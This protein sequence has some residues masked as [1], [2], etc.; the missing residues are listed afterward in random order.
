MARIN[1]RPPSTPQSKPL[2]HE[3]AP[4][5]R[6]GALAQ[7]RRSVLACLL[8][9]DTFYEN[10]QAIAERIAT[11]VPQCPPED[12]A[13]LAVEARTTYK[14]RHVPLWLVRHLANG[15]AGARLL[16][17]RT[18]EMVIQR[19]DELTEFVALYWQ[20]RKQALSA[21]VK[22][23]LA[24]AF[25]KFDAYQL[26]KY[27]RADAIKLRDVLFLC[28]A[29][30]NG[31]EQDALWKQLIS[32]TLPVPDTWEVAISAAKGDKEATRVAWDRLLKEGKLGALA[33]L[34]NLRNLQQAGIPDV[35][36]AGAL[37]GMDV[38]R[39]LPFRFISAARHA[40]QLEPAL[41]QAMFRA[42]T[43][44]QRLPGKTVL[45][46]DVSGS[47]D[48]HISAKSDLSRMD[49]ACALAILLREICQDVA[50][51]SFSNQ[52]VLVPPRRGFALRDAILISQEHSGTYT[53]QAKL[54]ADRLGYDRLII[55]TDEQS[56]EALSAPADWQ[57]KNGIRVPREAGHVRG[58]VINVAAYRNGIGYGP[59]THIDGWSEAV[60]TYMQEV[61]RAL[62]VQALQE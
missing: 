56:H 9:E 61:E 39:V 60:V 19:P 41:E 52:A 49:A 21:Q 48:S 13:T 55:I 12:V 62:P 26:A 30:P 37:L 31:P 4:A 7:L 51:L 54:E 59:W 11:L 17:A 28:H 53:E 45:L 15:T 3:G 36:I 58:Y 22:K 42:L 10:G 23:G 5:V 34:R 8:W 35:Q 50:V 32:G 33:L 6:V 18:L 57:L 27:N 38:R 47:M 43:T 16:V 46:V 2:T 44:E 25:G 40:P 20:Q 29:R 24:R 1:T 14:L